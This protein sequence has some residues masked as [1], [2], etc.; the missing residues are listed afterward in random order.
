[1]AE[2]RHPVCCVAPGVAGTPLA[3]ARGSAAGPAYPASPGSAAN[4]PSADRFV[5]LPGGVFRMGSDADEGEPADGEA[6]SRLVSLAPFRIAATAVSRNT[7]AKASWMPWVT[8]PGS[9]EKNMVAW[10]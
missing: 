7:G 2:Q 4:P 10:G 6:P 5:R 1:M 3:G 9:A 8:V